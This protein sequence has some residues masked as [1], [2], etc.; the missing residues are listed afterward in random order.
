MLS[1]LQVH[2]LFMPFYSGLG[3]ILMMHRIV[4]ESNQIRIHNHESL[5]ISPAQLEQTLLYYK[6]KGY[7]FVSLD[8][9]HNILMHGNPSKPFV[10]FTFDDG[11][12]DNYT[13][14]YP[15]LKKHN[16]PFTIYISN[17][18][19]NRT[20]KLWWYLLE[21]LLRVNHKIEFY[22]EDKA[23]EF[24]CS[25]Q[26]EKESTFDE[27]RGLINATL[28][29]T[30]QDQILR[31]I[32]GDELRKLKAYAELSGMS[33]DEIATINKDPLVTIACHTKNHLSLKQLGEE[34]LV[35]EVIESRE[36]IEG[37]IGERVKH[38]AYPFGKA[39]EASWREFELIKALGFTTGVTT[40]MGNIFADHRN[41]LECL[42]RININQASQLEVLELQTSGLLPF[43]VHKGKKVITH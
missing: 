3:Q 19:P 40:R 20:V 39:C 13:L 9:L 12:R 11:Y 5:E 21:D 6:R 38:F 7:Q 17:C 24:H 22:W 1:S 32:F 16:I 29:S 27:I 30:S 36:E 42:P 25:T 15:I 28:S 43:I 4:Q 26:A 10:S 34:D 41:H 18:F 14:A 2:R 37:H 35:K 8:D 31:A 23:Y 33:W